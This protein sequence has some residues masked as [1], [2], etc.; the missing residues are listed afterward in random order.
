MIFDFRFLIGRLTPW[1][2]TSRPRRSP[3]VSRLVVAITLAGLASLL[4]HPSAQGGGVAKVFVEVASLDDLRAKSDAEK[5][6]A[7]AFDSHGGPNTS[8]LMDSTGFNGEGGGFQIMLPFALPYQPFIRSEICGS[9]MVVVGQAIS[10]RVLF[11]KSETF[12]FTDFT[13]RIDQSIRPVTIPDGASG[14][15][16]IVSEAGGA[17]GIRS[18]ENGSRPRRAS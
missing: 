7:A 16:V 1:N 11:N 15:Y 8:K 6:R 4:S 9:E 14:R 3:S 18:T 10:S 5:A 17:V 13:F 2:R 12:L